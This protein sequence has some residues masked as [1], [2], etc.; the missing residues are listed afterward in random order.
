VT[1]DDDRDYWRREDARREQIDRDF[2]RDYELRREHERLDREHEDRTRAQKSEDGWRALRDGNTAEA[3]RNF[4]GP[5]ATINYLRA[6][7][8][9]SQGQGTPRRWTR[10]VFVTELSELVDNVERVPS[11]ATF[12]VAEPDHEGDIAVTAVLGERTERFW[13]HRQLLTQ[14]PPVTPVPPRTREVIT[15]LVKRG[16]FGFKMS[17]PW[18]NLPSPITSTFGSSQRRMR[19][20]PHTIVDTLHKLVDNVAA[21]PDAEFTAERVDRDGDGVVEVRIGQVTERF[22]VK[23]PLLA[24]LAALAKAPEATMPLLRAL[25]QLRVADERP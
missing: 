1:R 23:A 22:Y 4:A 17:M 25:G 16:V 5:D 20:M 21:T 18:L 19:R 15:T 10:H 2:W 7:Q 13:V 3:L 12:D 11:T 6:T 9:E 8:S 24:Q 14:L